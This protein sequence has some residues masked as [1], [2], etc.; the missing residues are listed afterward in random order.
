[1]ADRLYVSTDEAS[2]F[3]TRTLGCAENPPISGDY[4]I[5]DIIISTLQQDDIFGW[6][7]VKN[8]NPG[9]WKII[10]DVVNIKNNLNINAEDIK[11]HGNRITKNESDIKI[12]NDAITKIDASIEGDNDEIKELI[13]QN[14]SNIAKN[15]NNISNINSQLNSI[16]GSITELN[17]KTDNNTEE[18]TELYQEIDDLIDLIDGI[19]GKT[20]ASDS[21]IID[22]NSQINDMKEDIENLTKEL[23]DVQLLQGPK[24]DTGEQGPK[25][26]KGDPGEQGPKGDK[27][28]PGEQ[29]PKGDKGDQGE[30]GIQG[31]KG[32]DGTSVKIVGELETLQDLDNLT[33]EVVGNG[34]I[35]K[36]NGHLY[37]CTGLNNF[38]DVGEIKGPKG[39]KGEPGE[40][41]PKGDKGEQGEQGIQ[42]PKGD[43]GDPGEQGPKGDKGDQGEQGPKGDKGEQGE[44]GKSINIKGSVKEEDLPEIGD[45]GDGWLVNGDLY[46][47]DKNE[48]QW[49]NV[50]TIQGPKGDK[51]DQGEQGPKGDKGDQG[52]QGPKGDKGEAGLNVSIL[53]NNKP[54]TAD[55]QGVISLPNYPDLTNYVEISIV[56]EL[57]KR[58]SELEAKVAKLENPELEE[59][60]PDNPDTE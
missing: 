13:N 30:Q 25:G 35:I 9:E 51:G 6:V 36:E 33:D 23:E 46:I 4:N 2:Y 52:E 7:C 49:T 16:N 47:W 32:A 48:L 42:G 54:Y 26:D 44:D 57:I 27:G 60:A 3:I 50:G 18:I 10:C 31:P 28:D 34:Y 12:I 11:K 45:I 22:I 55:P 39:D 37:V 20:D 5:G 41:G 21:N 59:P 40:Q 14:T 38:T 15:N 43:K 8:G 19:D 1:M 58:I 24:G 29:G 17:T 53:L 56:N